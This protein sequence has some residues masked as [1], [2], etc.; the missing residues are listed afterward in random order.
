MDDS[1]A[2]SYRELTDRAGCGGSDH[3]RYDSTIDTTDETNPSC[4][5]TAPCGSGRYVNNMS[6]GTTTTTTTI[7]VV[8]FTADLGE[9]NWRYSNCGGRIRYHN[10][11]G[12]IVSTTLEEYEVTV[13]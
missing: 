2:V 1:T 3:D 6:G 12:A 5:I 10:C 13:E 9:L 4:T 7:K 11:G 8:Q